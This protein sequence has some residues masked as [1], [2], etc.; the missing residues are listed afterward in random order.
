M[1]N[2]EA[3]DIIKNVSETFK[4]MKNA[5]ESLAGRVRIIN[6]NSFTYSEIMQNKKR[7]YLIQ[8]I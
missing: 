8:F 3:L 5:S 7:N 1:Y 4:L 2:R 6:L